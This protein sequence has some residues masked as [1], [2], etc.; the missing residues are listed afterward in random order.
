MNL[1]AVPGVIARETRRILSQGRRVL[2]RLKL[3]SSGDSPNPDS[4]AGHTKITR[5]TASTS[6]SSSTPTASSPSAVTMR[7]SSRPFAI[8]SRSNTHRLPVLACSALRR[9]RPP[10]V[11]AFLDHGAFAV[12]IDLN[13]GRDNRYVM[14]GDFHQLQFA[15]RDRRC[16]VYELSRPRIRLRTDIVG[17]S[18]CAHRQRPLDL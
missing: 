17:G 4:T 16:R 12:G 13:P 7:G 10:E 11:R 18:S 2:M 6:A 15:R 14:V 5:R 1:R 3:S 8:D 9:A